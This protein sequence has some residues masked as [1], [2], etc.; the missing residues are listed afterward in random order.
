M[1]AREPEKVA[2]GRQLQGPEIEHPPG[3]HDQTQAEHQGKA[4]A[5]VERLALAGR[6]LQAPGNGG[7]GNGVVSRQHG[8]ER[9]Q[10]GQQQQ[11]LAPLVRLL[12]QG[13]D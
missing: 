11:Y 6:I 8:L 7:Q 13:L 10:Q 2:G 1:A 4:Q 9:H 5:Q 3:G 12:E